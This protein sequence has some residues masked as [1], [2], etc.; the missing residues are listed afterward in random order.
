MIEFTSLEH[1]SKNIMIKAVKTKAANS[2]AAEEYEKLK[3]FYQVNPTID[4][5]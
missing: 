4:C 5:L 1:T 2:K 3:A